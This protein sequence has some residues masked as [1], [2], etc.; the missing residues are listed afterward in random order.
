[1]Q[2]TATALEML[3][4]RPNFADTMSGTTCR[5][6]RTDESAFAW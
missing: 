1:M 3:M 2:V 4:T 6:N 5:H